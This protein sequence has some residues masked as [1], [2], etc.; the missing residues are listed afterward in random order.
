MKEDQRERGRETLVDCALIA[1]LMQS[2]ISKSWDQGPEIMTWAK[3]KSQMLN[4]L[5]HQ[6]PLDVHFLL[7]QNSVII[8]L[9]YLC[10]IKH[11][12]ELLYEVFPVLKTCIW[13]LSHITGLNNIK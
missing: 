8:A 10:F 13:S 9:W 4:E 7:T 11:P 6:A 12:L 2:L 5:H 3:T 1:S